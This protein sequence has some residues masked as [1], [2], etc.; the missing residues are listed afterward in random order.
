MWWTNCSRP[1]ARGAVA[2]RSRGA[3]ASRTARRCGTTRVSRRC[4]PRSRR[5]ASARSTDAVEKR[6]RGG[7]TRRRAP[8]QRLAA[9][10]RAYLDCAIAKP[11]LFALM[12]RP[13]ADRRVAR[14]GFCAIRHAAFERSCD[15]VR[16]AQDGGWHT[17]RDTRQ[18]AGSLWSSIHG[19]AT[20]WSHG[21][22]GAARACRHLVRRSAREHARAAD[23]SNRAHARRRR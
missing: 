3:R 19:L 2:A 18:L 17:A 22:Y 5:A 8:P 21:A 16:G 4:S 12:F 10:A 1:R 13:E 20:L 11:G 6:G 15:Y 9:G 14:N 23:R 7:R